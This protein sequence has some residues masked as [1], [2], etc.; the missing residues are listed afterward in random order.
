MLALVMRLSAALFALVELVWTVLVKVARRLESVPAP[1]IAPPLERDTVSVGVT[2]LDAIRKMPSVG[3]SGPVSSPLIGTPLPI[4]TVAL[5]VSVVV[6]RAAV[7]LRKPPAPAETV[8]PPTGRISLN[9]FCARMFAADPA[10]MVV[11]ESTTASAAILSVLFA[12]AP[13]APAIAAF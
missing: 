2:V 7:P 3:A 9:V 13:L 11:L 4:V 5:P 10:M 8:L 1:S 6:L 12:R